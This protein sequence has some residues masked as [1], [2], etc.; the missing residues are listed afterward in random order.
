LKK[1][2]IIVEIKGGFGNQLFQFAFA[3]SLKEQGY[4]V[5]VRTDFYNQ[6]QKNKG[7]ENTYRSLILSEKYFGFKKTG[8]IFNSFIDW[9]HKINESK[10]IKNLFG[11]FKNPF[12]IKL[13]DSNYSES[14]IN[15]KIIHLDGYWQNMD[16]LISQKDFLINSLSK[17][18][19]IKK[20]LENIPSKSSAMLIVRRGDYIKTGEDLNEDFY[21]TCI[22]YL[23]SKVKNL[24]LNIF[25]D[26]V[27]WV[28]SKDLF[29]FVNKI[30]G[31]EEESERV[32]D[33]FSVMLNHHHFVIANSTF[34]LMAAVLNEK[35]DSLILVA[36][37]WFKNKDHIKLTKNS[38][39]KIDNK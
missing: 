13:K 11:N 23:E 27:E 31:P 19:K 3:N 26:D 5:K 8:K 30:Y 25:T 4:K 20:S 38:W 28:K 37:P 15:K 21:K 22:K 34:S 1:I 18:P 12:F 14:L 2:N 16:N 29:S 9:N 17:N 10:K 39:I 35:N 7:Y 24:K 36:N 6:F 32:I 33:L